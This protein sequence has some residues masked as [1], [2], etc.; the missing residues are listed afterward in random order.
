MT[1]QMPRPIHELTVGM[2]DVLLIGL[3]Q[4]GMP[5]SLEI[6]Y[7]SLS[8]RVLTQHTNEPQIA[9][10]IQATSFIEIDFD[11]ARARDLAKSAPVALSSKS[12]DLYGTVR[13]LAKTLAPAAGAATAVA[14]IR[15]ALDDAELPESLDGTVEQALDSFRAALGEGIAYSYAPE[16]VLNHLLDIIRDADA[17]IAAVTPAAA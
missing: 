3:A 6:G 10:G 13:I 1:K 8:G 14:Q 11:Q 7:R 9:P 17:D 12:Q 16:T 2:G 15:H 5:L 4:T